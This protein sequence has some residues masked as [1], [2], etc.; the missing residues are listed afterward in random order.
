MSFN[1]ESTV[2]T[3]LSIWSCKCMGLLPSYVDDSL[4]VSTSEVV[5][6]KKGH[7]HILHTHT[8]T[9]SPPRLCMSTTFGLIKSVSRKFSVAVFTVDAE[10]LRKREHWLF[11]FQSCLTQTFYFRHIMLFIYIHLSLGHGLADSHHRT[12]H[13]I[14]WGREKRDGKGWGEWVGEKQNGQNKSRIW[15]GTAFQNAVCVIHCVI[16]NC[17]LTV[18]ICVR[19]GLNRRKYRWLW[20]YACW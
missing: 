18:Y 14:R 5:N 16:I 2:H 11:T 8:S 15:W 17:M 9:P 6:A 1:H 13:Q 12:H 20:M 10:S 3:Q 7:T 19:T 4:Q